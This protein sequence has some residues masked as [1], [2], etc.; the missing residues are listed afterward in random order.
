SALGPLFQRDNFVFGDIE[1]FDGVHWVDFPDGATR[2]CMWSHG[3]SAWT[4]RVAAIEERLSGDSHPLSWD[5]KR[6]G[7]VRR[8]AFVRI[9]P[10]PQRGPEVR[11]DFCGH[12]G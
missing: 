5:R 7:H 2:K 8:A 3:R 1:N 6:V 11:N 10:I 4:G 9:E 12:T